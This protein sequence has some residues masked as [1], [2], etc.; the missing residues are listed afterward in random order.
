MNTFFIA[1]LHF[2]DMNIIRYENRPFCSVTQMNKTLIRNW[3]SV[4]TQ[5]D[6]V[7]VLGD[8]GAEKEESILLSELFGKKYLVK[9]NHDTNTNEYYRKAG[10]SEVYD[11]PV[12]YQQFWILS[13]EPLY[14]NVNMPYANL[15]GHIHQSPLFKD[16]SRHHFCVSAER[17]DYTPVTMEEIRKK[18]SQT[19]SKC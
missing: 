9:G 19:K 16:Y 1:D 15:F 6:I 5:K 2:S 11:M 4:V 10:F 13:H 8:F 12:I 18:I 17:I 14:I 7:Y 3:N